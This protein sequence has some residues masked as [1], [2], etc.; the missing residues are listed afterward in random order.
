VVILDGRAAAGDGVRELARAEHVGPGQAVRA[1]D[2]AAFPH[3]DL[4]AEAAEH[5]PLVA[6][7]ALDQEAGV[8]LRLAAALD[9]GA[10]ELLRVGGVDVRHAGHVGGHHPVERR[11]VDAAF[12]A[13]EGVAVLDG[14]GH[15]RVQL[16]LPDGAGAGD[17]DVQQAEGRG[18]RL[19]R[20]VGGAL[21]GHAGCG[22]DIGVAG[23]VDHDAG[24]ELHEAALVDGHHAGHAIAFHEG[25]DDEGMVED[26][27][28]GGG[29][30]ALPD[31][32]E[33]LRVVGDAL[34]GAIGVGA[35]HSLATPQQL[36]DHQIGDAA[37][38]LARLLAGRVE[39]VE[40]VQHLGADPAHEAVTLHQG[41]GSPF[42]RGGDGRRRPGGAAADHQ[43]VGSPQVADGGGVGA[44]ASLLL[45]ARG[46]LSAPLP[47]P[48][49]GG[50]RC[51][52]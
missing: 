45:L 29:R 40:R 19:H 13:G 10:G 34:P 33:R 15:Q 20:A 5:R 26:A 17:V 47:P 9:L 7:D 1:E 23:G 35:Q 6:G 39:A 2:A 30:Q 8:L 22:G 3:A 25:I 51:R 50:R 11:D 36:I 14:A 37:D 31:E 49:P 12:A 52:A 21:I 16:V 27:Y 42:P 41:D 4:R 46:R 28:T 38:D 44:H 32:L 24:L 18:Q 48:A 43:H